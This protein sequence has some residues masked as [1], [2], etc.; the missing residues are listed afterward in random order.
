MGL[1][2]LVMYLVLLPFLA[3]S[4]SSAD[5]AAHC[6][7]TILQRGT[8]L[9][10]TTTD[11][12][13]RCLRLELR[14]GDLTS[15]CP[16]NDDADRI[17]ALTNTAVA[18][19][20][21]GCGPLASLFTCLDSVNGE[22]LQIPLDVI[23]IGSGPTRGAQLRCIDTMTRQTVRLAAFEARQLAQCTA[24]V[25]SGTASYG[26]SGPTCDGPSGTQARMAAA[27]ARTAAKLG[28]TCGGPDG[29]AGTADDL[30]P[31]TDLG[32]AATCLGSPYCEFAIDTLP[33]LISC[34]SCVA[35][36]EVGQLSRGLAA[37]PLDPAAACDVGK[38]QALLS[39]LANDMRDLA[40]CEGRILD[41]HELGPCPDL[42]TSGDLATN[43]GH[44]VA[45]VSAACG[46]FEGAPATDIADLASA[47]IAAL[48]PAHAEEPDNNLNRCKT[49]IGN[50]ATSTSRYARR[51]LLAL[52]TCTVQRACGQTT[53]A[54][55]D[56]EAS[57]SIQRGAI[58]A[59]NDIHDRC[60][61][62][63]PSML[64][65]GP[66]CPSDGSCGALPTTTIDELI[67]CLQCVGDEVVDAAVA[68]AL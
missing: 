42:E 17:D 50:S 7:T 49:E 13:T 29:V 25:A 60:D 63:T 56:S 35:T 68:L 41:G 44:Y 34:A 65:Y 27:R 15:S 40:V 33:D 16:S 28:R 61:A 39:L 19:I 36:G 10:A 18:A 6:K 24:K 62:Y 57:A 20:D 59:A 5:Q 64:G 26:P 23:R 11:L 22:A 46:A 51:K 4:A 54:C 21:D 32:F 45:G 12:M 52:R 67:T 3:P 58:L 47:L 43:A 48:Y 8:T 37:E 55:P 1:A 2:R 53:A 31:Q 38:H 9:F 66:T 30:D 14:T